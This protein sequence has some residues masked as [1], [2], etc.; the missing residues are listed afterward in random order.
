MRVAIVDYC[1]GNLRSVQKG[2]ELLG[3]E[4]PI[5][6]APEDIVTADAAVLPG[7]GAFA[8]AAGS[9]RDMG[10]DEALRELLAAGKPFL[11]ICLGLH[12]LF[13]DGEEGGSDI[14]GLCYQPGTSVRLPKVD[15]EGNRYKIPHVGWNT[16]DY[17]RECPLFDGIP[18]RTYFYFT[19]SYCCVPADGADIVATTTHAAPFCSVAWRQNAYGVQFHPEKSSRWGMAVLGNFVKIA[20]RG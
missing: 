14:P 18:D 11:G 6:T 5:V 19:H 10:Q 12:R 8:D 13:E 1:K 4:A 20:E 2:L 9:M 17:G 7:V 16:V 3:V 15:G